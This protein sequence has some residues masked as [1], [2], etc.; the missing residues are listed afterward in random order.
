[1][2]SCRRLPKYYFEFNYSLGSN[3]YAAET[4]FSLQIAGLTITDGEVSDMPTFYADQTTMDNW[5][6]S[7]R[8]KR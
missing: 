2:G 6:V 7:E 3:R 4:L 8:R 1:M 5:G